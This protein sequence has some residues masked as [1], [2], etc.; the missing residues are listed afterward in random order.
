MGR[1]CVTIGDAS[2][3]LK[4]SSMIKRAFRAAR[5]DGRSYKDIADEPQAILQALAI[6]ILAAAS[7]GVGVR[8]EVFQGL[9]ESRTSL[10]IV[11]ASTILVGWVVWATVIYLI[12]TWVFG[13]EATHRILLRAVGI[14]YSPGILMLLIGV[15]E[16]GDALFL[17][18]LFWLLA[19][20]TVAV[21]EV[22]GFPWPR[23]I[24][25]TVTGWIIALWVLRVMMLRP[26]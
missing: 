21:R 10:M 13:G 20:V 1:I 11:A 3:P 12:G 14:A 24:A 23:A 22:Q 19:S 8:D 4:E 5:L 6:V 25:S 18:S 7:F 16:V 9:Q 15:P 17:V 26:V 2:P